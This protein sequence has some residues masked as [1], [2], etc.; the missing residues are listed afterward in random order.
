MNSVL[1][2][3]K[4]GMKSLKRERFFAG[5]NILGLAL[6]MFCFIITS[7]YVKD[8]LTYDK[9]HSNVERIYMPNIQFEVG[10]AGSVSML[11]PFAAMDAFVDEIPGVENGVKIGMATAQKYKVEGEWFETKGLYHTQP[12]IFKIFDFKLELGYEKTALNEPRSVIISHELAQKHFKNK[13]PVGQNLEFK[14]SGTFKITGV[15]SPI[16][17]NSHLQFDMLTPID[18]DMTPYIGMKDNWKFGMGLDY[19]LLSPGYSIES[20]KADAKSVVLKHSENEERAEQ[21]VFK[22]FGDLY[23]QDATFRGDPNS[24]FGGNKQYL[25]IFSLVGIMLLLVACFN[26]I[27]LTTARSFSKARDMAVM[28]VIGASRSRLILMKIGETLFLAIIALIISL[29]A[30]E[31]CLP[32]ISGILGKRLALDFFGTPDLAFILL[33]LLFLVV[34][35]SG[36]YPAMVA[37]TFDLS[38]LLKGRTAKSKSNFFR[39]ALVVFQFLICAGFLASALIIRGQANHLINIDIGYNAKNVLSFDVFE[40]GFGG[41]YDELRTELERIPQIEMVSG[42]PLPEIGSI[43]MI[44]IDENGQKTQEMLW[45]GSADND[46][47]ELFDL[48]MVQGTSFKD[49]EDSERAT[50]VIVNEMAVKQLKIESPIGHKLAGGMVIKGV[51]KD[52]HFQSGKS[53]IRPLLITNVK[54]EIR[55]MQFKFREGDRASVVAQVNEVFENFNT[56]KSVDLKDVDGVFLESYRKEESLVNIFNILTG[57][58]VLVAFLG[59][60][61]LTAFENQLREKEYS[62]R[63]VLGAGRVSLMRIMNQRFILLILFSL[64]SSVPVTYLLIKGWLDEFPYRIGSTVPYFFASVIIIVSIT[65]LVLGIHGYNT[66]KKNPVDIL[67]NE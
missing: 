61:A 1:R 47:I 63:K 9:W 55:N 49:I 62:I 35:V 20:L 29:I 36:V 14:D 28:K 3:L 37:S 23:M 67:R 43:M 17:G 52:F 44:P 40:G 39:K 5:I 24:T 30:V 6:G 13:N 15:L 7:L 25:Y 27:N 2:F 38:S 32:K 26:Y 34:V 11:P 64:I 54:S 46:F 51:V 45:M 48:D 10:G 33:G 18:Y 31:I 50:A 66:S 22:S 19:L 21:Y 59:L 58:L 60:F 65:V 56:G 4:S 41:K 8:E 16:P 53:E 12:S 42:S 57:M